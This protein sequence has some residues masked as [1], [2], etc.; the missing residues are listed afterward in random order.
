MLVETG[1]NGSDADRGLATV[2][3]EAGIWWAGLA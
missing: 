2:T 3:S 1:R